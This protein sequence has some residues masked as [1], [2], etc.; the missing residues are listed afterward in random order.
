MEALENK[1]KG[2]GPGNTSGGKRA[3]YAQ[4]NQKTYGDYAAHF[5]A[6][7]N[8]NIYLTFD[9]GY[10]YFIK[11]ENGKDVALT[12]L[13]LDTLKEKNVKAV[14]FV[15]M[16]YCQRNP[17]L[18]RRMINEGHTVGNHSN[19]HPSM[20]SLTI[21][22]MEEEITSLH[23]YVQENFDY[24]MTLFR[25][26]MGE[27]STRSLA[28]TQNLGYESVFWS[29]AYA[30]WD[31]ENQPDSDAAYEKIVGSAHS[32]AIYLLHAVSETNTNLLGD[33]ID[34]FRAEGYDLVLFG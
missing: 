6:P 29:F 25:P 28:V 20:P 21:D 27:F 22:K 3:P 34:A 17:D 23:T 12:A 24:T 32:G 2:Y 5:I 18:V 8:G 31:T 1:T 13:I 15:T 33:V 11:D 9:C 4:D 10:E 7:D 30:D 16:S 26:P 14:F 19:S